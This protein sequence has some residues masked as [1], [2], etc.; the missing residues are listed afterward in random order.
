MLI[1]DEGIFNFR[2]S[3]VL[4][5]MIIKSKYKKT[6]PYTT[7]D[8]SLIRELMCPEVH[9]N[10]KQSLAEAVIPSGSTTLLHKHH[11]SEE[12]Y[13]ITSGE[14]LMTIGDEKFEVSACDTICIPP[15]KPHRIKNTGKGTLIL[16]CCCSP[17][18]SHNDTEL[19]IE[20]KVKGGKSS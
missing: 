4:L 2:N 3:Q 14:G 8:G 6:R 9:G 10:N 7:K 19:L 16:L 12:I 18:Y 13:H 11:K 20:K 17:P 1:Q 5:Q 15:E